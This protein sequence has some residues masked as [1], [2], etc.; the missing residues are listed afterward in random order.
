MCMYN[1]D[2]CSPTVAVEMVLVSFS[3]SGLDQMVALCYNYAMKWRFEYNAAKC[4][5]V[6]CNSPDKGHSKHSFHMG[7]QQIDIVDQYTHLGITYDKVLSTHLLIQEACCR[8]RGTFLSICN[9]GIHPEN[10][11]PLTSRTIYKSVVI[12]KALYGCVIWS[13]LSNTDIAKLEGHIG[14]VLNIC[15]DLVLIRAISSYI[16]SSI[17]VL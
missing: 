15:R 4:A 9:S 14:F 17:W 2:L 5:V 10:L 12:P 13:N 16:V 8:L 6:I 1:I 7:Q 3:K 11:N